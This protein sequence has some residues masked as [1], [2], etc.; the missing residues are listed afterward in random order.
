MLTLEDLT[1]FAQSAEPLRPTR[2]VTAGQ[3]DRIATF[4]HAA[5]PYRTLLRSARNLLEG[6]R[7]IGPDLEKEL[8]DGARALGRARRRLG[9][10]S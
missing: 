8:R 7:T 6:G 3:L 1:T 4:E 9:T 10:P 5:A 2:A